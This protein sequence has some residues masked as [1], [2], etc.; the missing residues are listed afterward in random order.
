MANSTT[1]VRN[2]TQDAAVKAQDAAGKALEAGHAAAGVAAD[3]AREVAGEALKAGQ[4]AVHAMGNAAENATNRV[5]EG[6]QNLGQ[7]VR[8]HAPDSGMLGS[9]GKTMASTLEEGGRYIQE[10]GLSGMADD[11]TSL[12]K[13]NPIPALLVGVG[14]GFL[15]ARLTS[16]S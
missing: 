14:I 8:Q 3:K 7:T 10:E 4:H 12:I 5:G 11:L 9:A 2:K 16:R 13:K 6:I 1:D 15:L